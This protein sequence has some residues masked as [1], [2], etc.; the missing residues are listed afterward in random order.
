MKFAR[1]LFASLAAA[2]LMAPVALAQT[3]TPIPTPTTPT[4]MEPPAATTTPAVSTMADRPLLNEPTMKID[5]FATITIGDISTENLEGASVYGSDDKKIGKVEALVFSADDQ[6]V[7]HLV[8]DIG[9]FLRMGVH[10]V[11]LTPAEV[12]IMRKGTSNDI[13][14]YVDATE[15]ELEAQPEHKM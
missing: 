4:Q 5:G 1:T 12:Q 9:G 2:T 3:T 8:L 7:D 13:R 11:A 6:T 14:V 10:R 15:A